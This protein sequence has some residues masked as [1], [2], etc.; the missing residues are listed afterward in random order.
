LFIFLFNFNSVFAAN[1]LYVILKGLDITHYPNGEFSSADP[2]F[3]TGPIDIDYGGWVGFSWDVGKNISPSTCTT[4]LGIEKSTFDYYEQNPTLVGGYLTVGHIIKTTT[5]FLTCNGITASVLV[6]VK[7]PPP[8]VKITA[9]PNSIP[10]AGSTS[11]NATFLY[12]DSCTASSNPLYNLWNGDK[13]NKYGNEVGVGGVILTKTTTF[14]ISCTGSGGTSSDSVTVIVA[15]QPP[16][17]PTIT[18]TANPASVPYSGS[19]TLT[20]STTNADSCNAFDGSGTSWPG[21]KSVNGSQLVGNLFSNTTFSLT[22]TGLGGLSSKSVVVSVASPPIPPPSITLTANPTIVVAGGETNLTW[23]ST[24]ATSC[25]ASSSPNSSWN[26]AKNK[27]G[28]QSVKNINAD[29]TFTLDCTG[30]GGTSS[31]TALVSIALPPTLSLSATPS[32]V[33]YNAPTNLTW[34]TTNATSCTASG[35]WT[36]NKSPQG[37]QL[38]TLLK[39]DTTFN[40]SC[41]GLG[42]TVDKFVKVTVNAQAPTVNLSASP[43]SVISGGSTNLSWTSTN[44]TSCTAGGDWTGTKSLNSTAPE[45]ISNITTN[46]T[47]TLTCKNVQNLETTSSVSVSVVLPISVTLTAS[48]TSVASGGS[49]Q[50][51]WTTTNSPTTCTAGGDWTG[52]KAVTGGS[53]VIMNITEDQTFTITC[54]KG[55]LTASASSA[56]SSAT[57]KVLAPLNVTLTANPNPLAEGGNVTLTW[58]GD[59]ADTCTASSTPETTWKGSRLSSGGT[60]VVNNLQEAT[61]FTITCTKDGVNTSKSVLVE[62]VA[63]PSLTFSSSP[64]SVL[65]GKD[66]TLTWLPKNVEECTAS[67]GWTGIKNK[68]GGSQTITGINE[69]TTFSLACTGGG[70]NVI[71]TITVTVI[72]ESIL[73]TNTRVLQGKTVLKW[74]ATNVEDCKATTENPDSGIGWSGNKSST[75]SP[76]NGQT[77]GVSVLK[78]SPETTKYILT[79]TGSI[80]KR[81]FFDDVSLHTTSPASSGT[82]LPVYNEN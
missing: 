21:Y 1:N 68:N 27:S 64:T 29:T 7:I 8:V 61:N 14:S 44:A 69:N 25:T 22:C 10:Y 15:P 76:Y 41:T 57:V 32:N 73:L 23:S 56:T 30:P 43:I 13:T 34:T 52:N 58:N 12:A 42:G 63:V 74:S 33:A 6:R 11:I 70:G 26:G 45:T 50:L 18:L 37:S 81:P 82:K 71:K 39:E 40:L 59:N 55:A 38:S 53:Q 35:G 72:R 9:T 60:E 54:T 51:T 4:N 19:T 20:W 67:G 79:C 31:Q 80:S 5:Y 24:N 78:V 47:F 46:K 75:P 3:S 17:A 36:G 77:T 28:T 62:I 49:T 16:P 66:I 2:N 48:P 65:K